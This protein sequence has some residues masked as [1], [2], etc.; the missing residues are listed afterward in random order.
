MWYDL[1]QRF[2]YFTIECAVT[3]DGHCESNQ[4]GGPH[5]IC[6]GKRNHCG[7]TCGF[8][9][10]QPDERFCTHLWNATF[11][12]KRDGDLKHRCHLGFERRRLQRF[13]LRVA[14]DQRTIGCLFSAILGA[15]PSQCQRCCNQCGG[16]N[17]ISLSKTNN[18]AKCFRFRD[19]R[20]CVRASGNCS[21]IQCD[22]DRHVKH[23][24]GLGCVGSR[25]QRRSLR[26]N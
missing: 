21:T 8:D 13:F 9:K 26:N 22:R 11:H 7:G 10:Y 3:C 5:K 4:R 2:I 25:V 14:L 19:S 17:Q 16:S 18:C 24:S 15:F 23:G 1:G 6:F 12:R 20:H